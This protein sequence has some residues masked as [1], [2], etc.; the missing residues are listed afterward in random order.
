MIDIS[1]TRFG[2]PTKK[3]SFACKIK[4]LIKMQIKREQ[5]DCFL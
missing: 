2:L 1:F 5:F 4:K 3:K